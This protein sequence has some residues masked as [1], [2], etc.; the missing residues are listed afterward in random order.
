MDKNS[1]GCGVNTNRQKPKPFLPDAI[2][3]LLVYLKLNGQLDF[4]S[5]WWIAFSPIIVIIVQN[6]TSAV[7][8]AVIGTLYWIRRLFV[9]I[10]RLN[11]GDK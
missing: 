1:C 11:K 4:V 6:L 3:L 8:M 9:R 2:A 7:G 5:W 10:D